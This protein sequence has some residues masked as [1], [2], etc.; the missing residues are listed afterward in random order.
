MT[1]AARGWSAPG[2]GG[3]AADA[4]L[5]PAARRHPHRPHAAAPLQLR[6]RARSAASRGDTVASA[7]LASGRTLVARSF[8]YHRPRG[9]FSAGPEE[10]NALVTLGAGGATEP[11]AKATIVEARDGLRVRSQNAWPS[12]ALRLRRGQRPLRAVLRRRLLL[13]DLHGPGPRGWMLYEP[14][15]RRAAGL[16]KASFEPDPDR[17]ETAHAFCDVLVVGGGP[18]GLS[19]ALAAGRAGARVI[20]CEEGPVLGGALDLEDRI[21]DGEPARLAL[22]THVGAE[23]PRQRPPAARA[24]ASTATTTTTCSA[25]S[26]RLA[27]GR[28]ARSSGTGASRR[29]ASCSRPARWS[30]PSSFPGNDTPGVMLAGAALAYARR[31]GVAVGGDVVL[32]TNNDGGWQRALALSRAGVPVR[33]V[34]DPRREAPRRDRAELARDRRRVPRR[35]RRHRRAR[36]QGAAI[37]QGRRRS[38]PRPAQVSGRRAS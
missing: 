30:G 16:G 23:R 15:I 3:R 11:N 36:R 10:P 17:Y 2:P 4:G 20:L 34:V 19:A 21:G 28:R 24:S 12:L 29:G 31:Y 27:A 13:Q 9:V 1:F 25:R 5:P 18:A 6:R 37:G 33:A 35:P 26:R 14:F 32:F 22:P 38:T 7:L 8:K